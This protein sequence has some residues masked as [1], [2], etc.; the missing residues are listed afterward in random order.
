M[1]RE[2][3]SAKVTYI[4][5]VLLH[6]VREV[7]EHSHLANEVLGNLTC[8]ENGAL[9]QLCIVMDGP[10]GGEEMKHEANLCGFLVLF[11]NKSHTFNSSCGVT[12]Q[13]AL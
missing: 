13:S 5:Q 11:T 2:G 3:G 7:L 4:H 9:T 12:N 1:R 6:V 8:W 10:E